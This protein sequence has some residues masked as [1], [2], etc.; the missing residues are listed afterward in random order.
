MIFVAISGDS[1]H[2][3]HYRVVIFTF[4]LA[5]NFDRMLSVGAIR[6]DSVLAKRVGWGEVGGHSH[7]MLCTWQLSWLAV[8]KPWLAL[9]SPFLIYEV[10]V[11]CRVHSSS[12][13]KG[14]TQLLVTPSLYTEVTRWNHAWWSP[15]EAAKTTF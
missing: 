11:G 12:V 8:E 6:F 10:Q 13:D 9:A 14:L 15:W 1:H 7:D 2:K 3:Y 4:T 5:C